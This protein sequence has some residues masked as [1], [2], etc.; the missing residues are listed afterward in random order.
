MSAGQKDELFMFPSTEG[1]QSL[2]VLI[3]TEHGR[4]IVIDGGWESDADALAEEIKKYGG[5]VD[6]WL[7]THLHSDHAGALKKILADE[8]TGIDIRHIYGSFATARWYQTYSADDSALAGQLL[9][10]FKQLPDGVVCDGIGKGTEIQIDDIR[11]EVMN[12]RGE[13]TVN[14]GNN[15]CLAYRL[16]MKGQ[17]VLFLGDLAYEAGEQLLKDAGAEGLKSDI[18]QMAHHGQSGVGKEVYAAID[19]K[20]CLWPTPQWLWDNDSGEGPGSG[21]WHT[22]ETRRWMEEL[23]VQKNLCTKDGDIHMIFR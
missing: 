18:V 19:P 16:W 11:I 17:S 22:L 2:S 21:P 6:A 3:R 15:S 12:D 13:Y 4:L 9:E 14:G 10:C 8:T 7:L 1:A 23:G 5:T 20:V